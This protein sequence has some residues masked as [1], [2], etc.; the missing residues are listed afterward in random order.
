M[1]LQRNKPRRQKKTQA[2]TN[3]LL[4]YLDTHPDATIRYHASDMI[5]H[6]HRD[7]SYILVSN[8]RSRLGGLFFLGN[9]PPSKISWMVP[10]LMSLLSSKTW[11]FLRPNQKVERASTTPK[12]APHSELHSH[13]WATYNLWCLSAQITPPHLESWMKPSNKKDQNQWTCDTIGCKTESAKK[14]LTFIGA[15]DVKISAIITQNI[16]HRNIT[17]LCAD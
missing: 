16:I 5:L 6:I 2:A 11:S 1:T 7:A 17:K 10:S 9:K 4:D 14:N 8:A 12:V 15:Q 3:Q 13:N